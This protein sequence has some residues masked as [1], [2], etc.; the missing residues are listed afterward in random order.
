MSIFISLLNSATVNTVLSIRKGAILIDGILLIALCCIDPILY[1]SQPL[2]YDIPRNV[3]LNL[4]RNIFKDKL[5]SISSFAC[6]GY[7]TFLRFPPSSR[8]DEYVMALKKT[9]KNITVEKIILLITNV[10]DEGGK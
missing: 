3:K 6:V 5:L 10:L 4:L 1:P 7:E 2:I 9:M 8:L